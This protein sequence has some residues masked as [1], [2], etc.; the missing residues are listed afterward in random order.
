MGYSGAEIRSYWC[1]ECTPA[2]DPVLDTDPKTDA[3][4][5]TPAASDCCAVLA[6]G[7]DDRKDIG[8]PCLGAR[9]TNGGPRFISVGSDIA[10][11]G[12]EDELPRW[13]SPSIEA[14]C[15]SAA[16]WSV[17]EWLNVVDDDGNLVQYADTL[18]KNFQNVERIVIA[19]AKVSAD[20]STSVEPRF[21]DDLSIKKLG[22]KRMFERWFA[23]RTS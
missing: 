2:P 13:R 8:E 16:G 1:N 5:A 21:F 17:Q 22:Y 4:A 11:V 14:L 7:P 20:G 3:P 9:Q 18:M 19:Y 12:K 23:G 10:V 15:R 6:V